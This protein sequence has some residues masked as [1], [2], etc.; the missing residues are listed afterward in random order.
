MSRAGRFALTVLILI[1]ASGWLAA[2]QAPAAAAPAA[3]PT[4]TGPSRIMFV[5]FS[6]VLSGTEEAKQEFAR[7]QGFVDEKNRENETRTQ[8]LQKRQQQFAEQERA[9]NPQTA[10]EMQ[11]EIAKLG[12]DLERFRE[13]IAAEIEVQRNMAFANLGQKIQTVVGESAQQNG[14]SAVLYLD[15]LAQS[16]LGGYFD[17]AYDITQDIISR[18]NVKYP[19]AAAAASPGQ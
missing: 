5:N 10:A 12:K 2:Q 8:D 11:R 18:Y 14:Y 13:D 3:V 17:P 4:A 16:G 19:V 6:Q 7:I 1:L 9:L 15:S